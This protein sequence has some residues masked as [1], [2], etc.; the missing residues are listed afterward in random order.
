MI[1]SSAQEIVE[2]IRDDQLGRE[3][4][5][6]KDISTTRSGPRIVIRACKHLSGR[7]EGKG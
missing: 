6:L 3:D 1:I 7:G 2:K 5:V 4:R